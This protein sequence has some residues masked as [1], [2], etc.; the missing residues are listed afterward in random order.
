MKK[1]L[2]LL[3]PFFVFNV[4]ADEMVFD[5]PDILFVDSVVLENN[6]PLPFN[7]ELNAFTQPAI[8]L[9]GIKLY[10]NSQPVKLVKNDGNNYYWGNLQDFPQGLNEWIYFACQY[11]N[12]VQLTKKAIYV[13]ECKAH[14]TPSNDKKYL[15]QAEFQCK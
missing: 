8:H 14:T 10:S 1:K 13:S 11:D 3:I 5:C 12:G 6:Q 4:Y 7:I 9:I 2:F 15:I